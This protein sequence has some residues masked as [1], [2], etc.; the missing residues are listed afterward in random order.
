MSNCT[1]G[2]T[3]RPPL[4]DGSH[5]M[6]EEAYKQRTERLNKIFNRESKNVDTTIQFKDKDRLSKS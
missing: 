4:C 6:S 3:T 5:Q 2:R 1:C